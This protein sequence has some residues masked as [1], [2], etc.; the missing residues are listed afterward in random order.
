MKSVP[1]PCEVRV[2][3]AAPR[4]TPVGRGQGERQDQRSNVK[5]RL[6]VARAVALRGPGSH[7]GPRV[8]IFPRLRPKE[9]LPYVAVSPDG[10]ATVY[11]VRWDLYLQAFAVA[12]WFFSGIGFLFS[13]G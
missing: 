9:R 10:G 7:C 4:F 6:V 11:P 3:I 2:R 12:I 8:D 1:W 13:L 5:P